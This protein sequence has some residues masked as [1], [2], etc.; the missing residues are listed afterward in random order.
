MVV[1]GSPVKLSSMFKG[2]Y[3]LLDFSQAGCGPCGERAREMDQDTDLQ[4]KLNGQVCSHATVVAADTVQD[5]ISFTGGNDT[6][7]AKGSYEIASGN[8]ISRA[9]TAFSVN[10][11]GTPTFILIDSTGKSVADGNGVP[12]NEINQYCK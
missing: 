5:W 2:K 7:T 8:N 10:F 4:A 12:T 11:I 6:W 3:M 1:N 9:A